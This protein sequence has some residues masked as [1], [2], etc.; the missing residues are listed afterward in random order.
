MLPI[1]VAITLI[2]VLLVSASR[3]QQGKIGTQVTNVDI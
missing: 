2:W 1:A 3:L